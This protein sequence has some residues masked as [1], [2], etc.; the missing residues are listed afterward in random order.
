[1]NPAT[2]SSVPLF[3]DVPRRFRSDVVRWADE[4][5]APPGTEIIRQGQYAQEFFV[6]VE[7]QADVIKDGELVA[8]LEPGQFF[9]E[10]GLLGDSWRTA[11]VVARTPMRLLVLAPREFTSLLRAAPVVA[12]RVH[13]AARERAS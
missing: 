2:I 9:G 12:E 4:V 7:G 13:D 1:M 5:D 6:I 11:S 8:T 3:G 10:V